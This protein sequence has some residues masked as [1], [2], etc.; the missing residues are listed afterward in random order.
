MVPAVANQL[1][2]QYVNAYNALSPQTGGCFPLISPVCNTRAMSIFIQL[3]SACHRGYRITILGAPKN[4]LWYYN[5]MSIVFNPFMVRLLK[6]FRVN[7][8]RIFTI[9][10]VSQTVLP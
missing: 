2:R 4:N 9:K 3:L 5:Y 7:Y 10:P 1:I 6:A 8:L